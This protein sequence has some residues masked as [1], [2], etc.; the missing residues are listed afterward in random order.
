[1]K[2]SLSGDKSP[3]ALLGNKVAREVNFMNERKDINDPERIEMEKAEREYMDR[4][5]IIKKYNDGYMGAG[6][7]L[8]LLAAER[9]FRKVKK[10]T[11]LNR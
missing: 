10:K 3:W 9:I 6:E 11:C 4:T 7:C 5:S 2:T 1:L 8:S